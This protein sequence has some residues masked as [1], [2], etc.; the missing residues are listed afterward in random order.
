MLDVADGDCVIGIRFIGQVLDENLALADPQRA[1]RLI[2]DFFEHIN[3]RPLLQQRE[4]CREGIDQRAHGR[5][6]NRVV[7]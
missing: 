2:G 5:K 7:G 1:T 4:V 6:R 3:G